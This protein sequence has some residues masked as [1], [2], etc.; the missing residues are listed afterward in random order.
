MYVSRLHV[1]NKVDF[2]LFA[3]NLESTFGGGG[4]YFGETLCETEVIIDSM[5]LKLI[6]DTTFEDNRKF[7]LR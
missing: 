1:F 6:I 2:P 5:I 7:E 4:G 3:L